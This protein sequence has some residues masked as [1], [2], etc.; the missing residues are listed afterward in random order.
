MKLK[1]TNIILNAAKSAFEN[2]EL[3]SS[4]FP[5]VEIEEPKVEVQG[6][7]ST[8][9]AMISA[10]IQKMP[11]RKIAEAILKYLDD[12]ENII[13]K[14]EIAGPGFI[15]F[16][17]NM[18]SWHP[19]LRKIHTDD[20]TYGAS[21]IGKGKKIQVEFVSANP[22]GPLHVGHGRGAAVGDSVA[23]LLAFCGYDVKKE[24]YVNDSGRQIRTLGL[25]VYLR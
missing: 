1:L 16:F 5:D 6:D 3:P 20:K 12:P 24:Y 9:I 25:S 13:E 22:T 10:S 7:L 21:D 23:R 2:G 17:I 18:A 19:V 14:T 11:P 4:E 8:N 15:N